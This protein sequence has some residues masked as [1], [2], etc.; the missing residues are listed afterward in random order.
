MTIRKNRK[1]DPVDW[2]LIKRRLASVGA[3]LESGFSPGAAQR[4]AIL[5]ARARALAVDHAVPDPGPEIDVLEFLISGDGY[6]LEMRYVQEVHALNGLAPLPCTPAFVRGIVNLHGRILSV[7]DLLPLFGLPQKPLSA[8]DKLIVLRE[9]SMSFGVLADEICGVRRL[10]LRA[11]QAV[12]V[13]ATGIPP[14][15]AGGV[16]PGRHLLLDAKSLLTDKTVVVDQETL[17]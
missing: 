5:Q 10:P 8:T 3:A 17:A 11:M 13:M 9:G 14:G 16:T 15:W 6:A 4:T 2:D 12:P 7:I 1:P